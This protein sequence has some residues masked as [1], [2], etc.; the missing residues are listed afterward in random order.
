MPEL[1]DADGWTL[2]GV[3]AG[4]CFVRPGD[5]ALVVFLGT[6]DRTGVL[7]DLDCRFV[8]HPHAGY[9]HRGFNECWQS[10]RPVVER[11]LRGAKTISITGHSL[12]GAMAVLA[13]LDLPNVAEVVTFGQPRVGDQRFADAFDTSAPPLTRYAYE[14]DAVPWI[15]GY[16]AGYRHCGAFRWHDGEQWQNALS[17]WALLK[18]AWQLCGSLKGLFDRLWSYHSIDNYCKALEAP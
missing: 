16:L 15:P 1:I 5:D 13:S 12:G 8:P 2:V 11:L 14:L 6:H 18:M 4:A 10:V 9:V 7:E 17:W 3:M